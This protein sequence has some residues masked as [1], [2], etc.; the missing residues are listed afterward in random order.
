MNVHREKNFTSS[1]VD[2]LIKNIDEFFSCEYYSKEVPGRNY[3]GYIK[4]KMSK[5]WR[6]TT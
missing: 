4:F 6:T 1:K 5:Y 3:E 2:I